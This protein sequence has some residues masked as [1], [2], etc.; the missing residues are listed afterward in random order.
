MLSAQTT[1]DKVIITHRS[2]VYTFFEKDGQLKVR[3]D[4]KEDYKLNSSL[5][6]MV[7]PFIAYSRD[8]MI[9]LKSASCPGSKAQ[10]KNITPEGI[11]FD[12]TQVCY[13]VTTLTPRTPVRTAKFSRVINDARYLARIDLCSP[14]YTQE[15]TI[16][17]FFPKDMTPLRLVPM[18]L[19][20]ETQVDTIAT[21]DGTNITFTLRHCKSFQEESMEPPHQY[22]APQL[23][24]TGL[25]SDYHELYK[26]ESRFAVTDTV[27]P[28]LSS[29]LAEIN[30]DSHS[31]IDR[32][33]NTFQWVQR[34]IRYIAFEAGDASFQPDSPSEVLRKRYGDCKGMAMLL[35]TLLR[36]QGFDARRTEIGTRDIPYRISQYPTLAAANHEICTVFHL[37][38]TYFLDATM[39]YLPLGYVHQSIQGQEAMIENGDDCLLRDVP[40]LPTSLSAD[41]LCYEYELTPLGILTGHAQ[42]FISGDLKEAFMQYYEGKKQGDRNQS[43][44]NQLSGSSQCEVS[45]VQLTENDSLYNAVISAHIEHTGAVQSVDNELYLDMNPHINMIASKID[46]L[47]RQ[48]DFWFP[49][50]HRMIRE[51]RVRLPKNAVVAHL[52][53]SIDLPV[54]LGRLSCTFRQDG[55][56]VIYKQVL[57]FDN[58]RLPLAQVPA[59]NKAI[60]R[61]SDTCN[62]QIIINRIKD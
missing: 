42:R 11:F 21:N 13:F 54:P 40:V 32:L 47:K 24:V 4:V 59:W 16:S 44:I 35:R 8:G 17:M 3:H 33:R 30:R 10:Y 57:Q 43:L 46:T 45:V 20:E 19:P 5:N 62:E 37:G 36:A 6:Q 22:I 56:T 31:D 9:T 12:D 34:N 28:S 26:W 52:P 15:R 7:Q 48:H 51:V 39:S 41:S 27:I 18:N 38:H 14:Y 23:L 25:F 58:Q 60:D 55:Y 49:F 29:L 2:D 50:R 1:D 61:W 53:Q